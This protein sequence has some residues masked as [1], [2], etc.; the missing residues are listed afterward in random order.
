VKYHCMWAKGFE[1]VLTM[2][3]LEIVIEYI[4]L[5]YRQFKIA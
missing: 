3:Q 5:P 2:E 1:L 4:G